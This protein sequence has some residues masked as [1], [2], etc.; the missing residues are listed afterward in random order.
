MKDFP[1]VQVSGVVTNITDYDSFVELEDGIEVLVH[2]SEMSWTKKNVHPG[3][4][5][6]TS[7][8]VEV[9]VLE[10]DVQKRRIS[11]GIKQCVEN[12]WEKYKNANKTGDIIEGEIR[13]ITE[14][15]VFIALNEDIDGL[16]H[17]SDLSWDGNGDELIKNYI[18][19]S[20]AQA[21]ILDI[22]VEKERI[23]LGINNLQKMLLP[24]KLII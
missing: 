14:F 10:I 1:W 16:V 23:S 11:L 6:S 13:N 9:M 8:K 15:G 22:D 18:K 17:L 2:V 24:Q 7:E 12:P 5:V 21:K 4:I 3:K 19:G 20:L